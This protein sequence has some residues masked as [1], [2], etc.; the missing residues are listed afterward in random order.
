MSSAQALLYVYAECGPNVSEDNFHD[1]YDKEHAP[2]RLTVPG[3]LSAVRYKSL[4]STKVPT[5]LAMYDM[6]N[7]GVLST[8]EYAHLRETASQNERDV[9]SRLMTLGRGIYSLVSTKS[10]PEAE[11]KEGAPV[12][13]GNFLYAVHMQVVGTTDK[14]NAEDAFL[15]WYSQTRVPLL[16]KVP[17]WI[18]SRI[19]R[20]NG[21][22]DM[23]G[24]SKDVKGVPDAVKTWEP[25]KFLALHEW[26]RD[27]MEI[28]G[29]PEFKMCMTEERPWTLP[30]SET[31]MAEMEDRRFGLY[32]A[33][34]KQ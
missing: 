6:T 9:I 3:F 8:K 13:S 25:M 22:T 31:P 28:T 12:A 2:A 16:S 21:Y 4:D 34:E 17:G 11:I 23:A 32:K 7:E 26:D 10:T 20:L 5:W 24:G 29:S 30:G 18:R 15:K 14:P 33:F 27:G 1:W 19:Y